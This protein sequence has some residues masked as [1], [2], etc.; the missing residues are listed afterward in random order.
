MDLPSIAKS[1]PQ[2]TPNA[3]VEMVCDL[4]L[5]HPSRAATTW[6]SCW[7]GWYR[8]ERRRHPEDTQRA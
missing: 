8:P 4:A 1:R 5:A 3:I 2:T 6:N 7:A